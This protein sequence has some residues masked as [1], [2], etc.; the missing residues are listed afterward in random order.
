MKADKCKI[1]WRTKEEPILHF[2]SKG[3]LLAEFLLKR[4]IFD[5]LRPSSDLNKAHSYYGGLLL[6][7]RLPV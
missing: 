5:L 1:C 6:I 2:K 7:Q 4:S 3:H